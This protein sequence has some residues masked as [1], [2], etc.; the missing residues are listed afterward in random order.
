M[1]QL[2]IP[3]HTAAVYFKK[4]FLS[5]LILLMTVMSL[6]QNMQAQCTPPPAPVVIPNPAVVC[7]NNGPIKLEVQP[8]AL[9]SQY[10]SGTV[11]ITVP[12][13]N[14]AGAS[15]TIAVAGI[16]VSCSIT[17]LAVT[18][19]MTHTFMGDMVFVLKAPNGQIINL[20]YRL[21]GT[22]GSGATTGFVNTV[23]S[24]TGTASLSTGTNPWTGSYKAD[25]WAASANPPPGPTGFLPTAVTWNGLYTVPNGNW[26]LAF[27][28]GAT[29]QT[30]ILNSWCLNFTYAC[31]N[32]AAAP[33]IWTPA[34]GLYLDAACAVPYVAGTQ[35]DIVYARPVVPGTYTYQVTHN[36]LTTPACTSAATTVTVT[37]GI[38]NTIA[39]QPA[40][41]KIC[42][43][44]NAQFTVAVPGT[45]LTYQWQVSTN[46]GAT[47]TNI[48]NA[49]IFSGASSPTL[50]ITQP[51]V[52]MS[53]QRYRVVV[54]SSNACA[55]TPSNPALLTVN[56]L[57]QVSFYAVPYT[58]LQPGQTT[59]LH[60]VVTPNPVAT[61]S[62]WKDGSIIPGAI[63]D[64]L[65]I[66]FPDIGVYQAAVTDINGC[67]GISDT[68]SIRDWAH[69]K[70]ILIYP[71]PAGPQFKVKLYSETYPATARTLIIYD[72]RG[73]KILTTAYTQNNASQQV[74]VDLRKYGKG[75]YLVEVVDKDGKRI[76]IAK[77]MVQ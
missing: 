45:G 25:L 1:V 24:S 50:T 48:V 63:A 72:N 37:A 15:S 52:S 59:T 19:N 66:G 68:M 31:S 7:I 54:S 3:L 43:G 22:G 6:Q 76:S 69:G 57:P 14:V 16:P 56:P 71:N 73:N 40:D 44:N 61:Y 39:T 77:V 4:Q 60:A 53:G 58:L 35:T 29:G 10:C 9:T 8:T 67:S 75:L 38:L 30:G 70:M 32:T 36:S 27:Y 12:D 49:G 20:N 34:A 21:S 23:I 65:V 33:A 28:D 13:N 41:Q 2:Y 42:A 11:N 5:G 18:I 64:T 62:W 46:G 55:G 26:T 51:P 47:F 74:N 17:G